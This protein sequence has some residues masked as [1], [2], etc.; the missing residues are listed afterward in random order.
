LESNEELVK[1]GSN[2]GPKHRANDWNPEPTVVFVAEIKE[3][4]GLR[5]KKDSLVSTLNWN[6]CLFSVMV[7]LALYL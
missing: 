4:L 2:N 1:P 3:R 7:N 5:D 6:K